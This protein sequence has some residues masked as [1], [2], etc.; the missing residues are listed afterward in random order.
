MLSY[1]REIRDKK[2]CDRCMSGLDFMATRTY[3][4]VMSHERMG[5]IYNRIIGY[6]EE[7]KAIEKD[8]VLKEEKQKRRIG[9]GSN[10]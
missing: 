7:R 6:N 10:C 1:F 2:V 8:R 4:N 9:G 5:W 3:G